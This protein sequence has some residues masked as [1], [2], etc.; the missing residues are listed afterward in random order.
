MTAS[1]TS[2]RRRLL[3]SMISILLVVV[4]ATAVITHRVGLYVA[5]QAYDRSLLDTALAIG[6]S[7]H[8]SED[9][10]HFGL[11]SEGQRALLFDEADTVVF[12]IRDKAGKLVA[13]EADIVA[14]PADLVHG[15]AYFY[16]GAWHGTDL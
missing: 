10:P 3:L 12:Q 16:D 6:E 14:P 1:P 5:T 2:I 8:V 11:S 7:V 15:H 9:G 13:G 4:V